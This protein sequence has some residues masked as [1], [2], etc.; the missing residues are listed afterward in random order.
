MLKH[1]LLQIDAIPIGCE[2]E[3]KIVKNKLFFIPYTYPYLI[4]ER[5]EIGTTTI[6]YLGL[7][8]YWQD[9]ITVGL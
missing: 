7:T 3:K 1:Y 9:Y 4:S 2:I 8:L 5:D 6:F